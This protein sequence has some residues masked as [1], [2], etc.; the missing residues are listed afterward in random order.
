MILRRMRRVS[1]RGDT[2]RS[3]VKNSRFLEQVNEVCGWRNKLNCD[4]GET[5]R[6][7]I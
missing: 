1:I 5:K 2:L 6:I 4:N 3:V 7:A